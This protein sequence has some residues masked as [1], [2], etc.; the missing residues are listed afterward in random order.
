MLE[1]RQK[2]IDTYNCVLTQTSRIAVPVGRSKCLLSDEILQPQEFLFH[3]PSKPPSGSALYH[4]DFDELQVNFDFND[5]HRL[6]LGAAKLPI[7][8]NLCQCLARS[9]GGG[10][11][12]NAGRA[13]EYAGQ[14]IALDATVSCR[15]YG[16]VFCGLLD[17]L[18]NA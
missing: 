16:T 6:S 3:P 5:E 12:E 4:V 15:I 14:A 11:G 18:R 8:L 7:L 13:T 9:G 1:I 17:V 10:R 2:T